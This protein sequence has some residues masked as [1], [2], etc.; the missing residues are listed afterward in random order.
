MKIES[1]FKKTK[2]P[3]VD[4]P[5][6][7]ELEQ[8]VL[9][10]EKNLKEHKQLKKALSD[11]ELQKNA[12]LDGSLDS[13]RLVDKEMRI[14]WANKI[15]ESQL[16]KD[17]KKIIGNY[18]YKA[19][20]GRNKPCPNCPTEKSLKSGKTEF[21]IICEK[22]VKG[23]KGISYWH[24]YSVPIKNKAAEITNFIQVSRNITEL[25]K[26]EIELLEEK[27][28]LEIALSK[29]KKLSGLLPICSHCKKIR[30]DKGYW[31][32]I[33][34]YIHKHSEAEFSHGICQ[35]CL[36]KHYPDIDFNEE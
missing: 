9:E 35:D 30:N 33:E 7:E 19:Y 17:R 11:S 29:V 6:Y 14:I 36:K 15:I 23:I 24:D 20:T 22:D 32:Q 34:S 28:K 4:K 26:V 3:I 13:I 1:A 12:I 8:R 27:K 2:D 5:T 25:K 18:C 10:L 21:S 31:I 16:G